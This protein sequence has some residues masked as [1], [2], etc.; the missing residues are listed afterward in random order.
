[1]GTI[2]TYNVNER[3]WIIPTPVVWSQLYKITKGKSLSNI[4]CLGARDTDLLI[5]IWK[6]LSGINLSGTVLNILSKS[7]I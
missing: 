3:K 5:I 4:D 1:M 2:I 7:F 6:V